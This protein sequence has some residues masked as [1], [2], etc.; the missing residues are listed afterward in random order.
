MTAMTI[1]RKLILSATA[2]AVFSA[3]SVG[4]ASG[5]NAAPAPAWPAPQYHWCPGEFWNPIWGINL[6]LGECQADGVLDR[7]RP[8]NWRG[9]DGRGKSGNRSDDN[10]GGDR[11]GDR[12]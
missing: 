3:G 6:N 9:D 11:G 12:R 1:S 7:D 4:L 8:D 10:R 5:A 2:A